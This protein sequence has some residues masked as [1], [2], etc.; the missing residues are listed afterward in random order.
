[1]TIHDNHV[2]K[3]RVVADFY[4]I[5]PESRAH[6]NCGTK[7]VPLPAVHRVLAPGAVTVD[8]PHQTRSQM[9]PRVS[10]WDR[11]HKMRT[12]TTSRL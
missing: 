9:D 7:G 2:V 10:R 8:L 12:S 5:P 6:E 1:M 11:D 4:D 3:H